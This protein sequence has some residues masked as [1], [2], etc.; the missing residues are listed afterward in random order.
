MYVDFTG[1]NVNWEHRFEPD[2]P[3]YME[4]ERSGMTLHLSEHFGDAAIGAAV[5]IRLD[6]IA[7]L[8]AELNDKKYRHARP[9]VVQQDWSQVMQIDDPI[10]NRLRFVQS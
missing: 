4:I 3:L 9:M 10:G 5:F 1:F 6:D 2:T 7:A 8:H